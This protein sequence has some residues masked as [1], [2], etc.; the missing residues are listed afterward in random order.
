VA[1]SYGFKKPI[2][3]KEVISWRP[4][5]WPFEGQEMLD[6]PYDLDNEPFGAVLM[7]NDSCTVIKKMIW[8]FD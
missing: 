1:K 5:I 7:F 3:S 8:I 4:S 2:I 6:C